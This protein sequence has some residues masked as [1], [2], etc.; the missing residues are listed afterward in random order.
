[1]ITDINNSREFDDTY[2][3][4]MSMQLASSL[5]LFEKSYLLSQ[6]MGRKLE[7]SQI[8]KIN[9]L[10]EKTEIPDAAG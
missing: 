6:N 1:M 3:P 5:K 9:D 2:D 10:I 8:S 7:P 4:D